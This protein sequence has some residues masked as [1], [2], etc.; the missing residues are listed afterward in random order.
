MTQANQ[1]TKIKKN[2]E[3]LSC[4]GGAFRTDRPYGSF[5]SMMCALRGVPTETEKKEEDE[6]WKLITEQWGAEVKCVSCTRVHRQP[7]PEC[8]RCADGHQKK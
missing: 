4:G 8:G 5:C 6:R 3:C 2:D 7:Q 1:Y